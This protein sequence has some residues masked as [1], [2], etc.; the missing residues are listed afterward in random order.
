MTIQEFLEE[1]SEKLADYLGCNSSELKSE[2][3]HTIN[4]IL[5]KV[6]EELTTPT[7]YT[8]TGVETNKITY[9]GIKW[10]IKNIKESLS[11]N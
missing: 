1:E 8:D 5:D 3:K 4:F 7:I 6:E 10:R 11:I 2:L 9:D